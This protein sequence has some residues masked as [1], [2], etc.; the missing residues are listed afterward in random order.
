MVSDLNTLVKSMSSSKDGSSLDSDLGVLHTV[1]EQ[2]VSLSSSPVV[3]IRNV[4]TEA[5]LRVGKELVSGARTLDEQLATSQGQAEDAKRAA[6]KFEREAITLRR[7]LEDAQ[8]LTQN[9]HLELDNLHL[10][11]EF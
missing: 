8:A 3:H 10:Q 2:L 5:V 11:S 9:L 1:V 4:V 7:Q 6:Q